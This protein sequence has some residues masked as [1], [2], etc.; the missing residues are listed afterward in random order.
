MCMQIFQYLKKLELETPEILHILE[1]G[2]SACVLSF[3]LVVS[4]DVEV[5]HFYKVKHV[6]SFFMAF[7][8][9]SC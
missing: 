6:L 5:L 8:L 4:L 2:H 3:Y 7:T 1:K 9:A